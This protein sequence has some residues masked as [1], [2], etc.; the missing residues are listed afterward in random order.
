V[1]LCAWHLPALFEVA[2]ARADLHALQHTSFL[3][4]AVLF[5]WAP[6]AGSRQGTGAALAYL[7]ITMLHTAALGALLTLS[8]TLW[9]AS[10][11]ARAA[12]LGFDPLADQQ[13][14]GLVMSVPGGLAYLLVG[15]MVGARALGSGRPARSVLTR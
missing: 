3:L 4:S 12:A 9:Y 1:V 10:Y 13:L 11:G 7:F 5:W 15:L 6:L 14:G 2:L 8:P